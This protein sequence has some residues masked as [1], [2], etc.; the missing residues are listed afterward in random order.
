[1]SQQLPEGTV[2]ILFTDVEGSTDLT[3]S[4]GDEPAREVLRACDELV[5]Q[6]V[7]RHRGQEVKGTG[8]GFMLAFTSARRAVAC[9]VDIQ[10]AIAGRNR[11]ENEQA[12]HLRIGLNTGEVIREEEDLFGATVIAAARIANHAN[13]GEILVSEA[14]K[15]VLGEA[16]T[17][18]LEDQGETQLKGFPRPMRLFTVSWEEAVGPGVLSLR[19]QTPFVGREAE[20]AELRRLLE[21]AIRGQGSLVLVGGE[22]GVG[23][24]RLA[25]ELIAEARTRGVFTAEG[26]CYEMEGAPPYVPFVEIIEYSARVVPQENLLRALGDSAPEV[27]KLVPRLRRMVQGLGDPLDL[28]PEQARHYMFESVCDFLERGSRLQPMLLVLDDLHWADDSSC[29]LLE[30]LAQRLNRMAVLTIGTYRDVDLVPETP[31]TGSLERLNRRRLAH[32]LSLRRFGEEEVRSM[33]GFLGGKE[34]P[35]GLVRVIFG[36]TEGIP[37]F[38]EEVFRH[39]LEEGWLFDAEGGWRS[40]VQLGEVEVPD[41]VRRVLSRRLERVSEPTREVLTQA[42]AVGRDFTYEFLKALTQSEEESLLDAVEEAESAHLIRSSEGATAHFAFWH[43]L[44]RQ[45]LLAGLSFPRR[46]RLHLRVAETIEQLFADSLEE[47]VADLAYQLSLAGEKDRAVEYLTRAGEKAAGGYANTEALEYFHRALGMDPPAPQHRRLLQ[48]RAKL[49]LGLFRGREAARDL[50]ALLEAARE[51]G[52]KAR[53][54]EALLDIGSAYYTMALDDPAVLDRAREA[55][56]RAYAL[57][58]EL[59]DKA[60]MAWSLIPT[61]RFADFWSGYWDKARANL[62]EAAAL[63]EEIGDEEII[64]DAKRV[65]LRFMP[66]VEA[67][68]EAE[69]IRAALESKHQLVRLNEHLFHLMWLYYGRGKFDRCIECCESGIQL[70]GRIGTEPVLYASIKGL[71][72][73]DLGHFGEAWDSFQREV[74]DEAH[75]FGRAQRDLAIAAYLLELM[76]FERAEQAARSVIE[77]ARILSRPWMVGWAQTILARSLAEMGRLHGRTAE[78]LRSEIEVAAGTH[79]LLT[80]MEAA[81]AVPGADTV[82]EALLARGAAADALVE[83]ERLV[84]GSETR[85]RGRDYAPAL[86]LKAR[87]LIKLGQPAE[88]LLLLDEALTLATDMNYR[89]ILWRVQRTR[90]DAYSAL[91][92]ADAAAGSYREA[93]AVLR[94]LADTIPDAQLQNGFLSNPVVVSTFR[95]AQSEDKKGGQR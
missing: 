62:Q 36:E 42:A 56:E 71:A 61:H 47:H 60:S 19:E 37:Y 22:A 45:T 88:A 4:L 1:M 91:G 86:E 21:Q 2:T 10:R 53:E 78:I 30:H 43:E 82:A 6:Q 63:G 81:G 14:V 85:G 29:L 9:A 83:A 33:L 25:E 46:Q 95:A 52:D 73:L 24:S 50:E 16:T 51:D 77:E 72:L 66:P 12:V 28:P 40:E 64:L 92:N 11:R 70:A 93:A 48:Q 27:V 67:E 94:A 55:L 3:T 17:V 18:K 65:A 59:G 23:K 84:A 79:S 31:L 8:D 15:V 75:P 38:V 76:A 34:P 49:L 41:S 89:R 74:A 20:R 32:Q 90:G 39:L 7:A 54:L 80:F 69:V 5:R 87:A 68:R 35:A 26:R 44:I 57:A 58:R 13:A